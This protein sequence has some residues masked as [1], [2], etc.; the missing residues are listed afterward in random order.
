MRFK[1]FAYFKFSIIPITLMFFTF[2]E[3]KDIPV[4][5][6][7]VFIGHW[8]SAELFSL[9]IFGTENGVISK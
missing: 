7:D 1:Y 5:L 4:K 2:P 8:K 6:F 9:F 3:E